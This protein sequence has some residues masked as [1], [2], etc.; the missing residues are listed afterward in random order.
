MKVMAFL[1]AVF[2]IVLISSMVYAED[3]SIDMLNK[4]ADGEKMVYSEDIARVNVGD[5]I[6]WLP[7]SKG[8]NVHFL[9]KQRTTRRRNARNVVE[10]QQ[11]Q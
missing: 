4:R 9:A 10:G 1:S 11:Q 8:H 2:G 6:T 3:I 7:K 5:T